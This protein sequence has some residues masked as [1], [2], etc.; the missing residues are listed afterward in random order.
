MPFP[1]DSEYCIQ[2]VVLGYGSLSKSEADYRKLRHFRP[3]QMT[4][5]YP[6][7]HTFVR[8]P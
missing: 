7:W 4:N 3:V 8:G 1:S 2:V 5:H 6:V